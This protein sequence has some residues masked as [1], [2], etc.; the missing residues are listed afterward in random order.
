MALTQRLEFRQSQSLV[1]T[2]QLMQAIKLLQLSNLD[3]A[4]FVES[5][6][7][8]NPM[9][10][11]A[12]DGADPTAADV[13]DPAPA[14]STAAFADDG[15]GDRPLGQD[16]EPAPE[17]WM[18]RDL[19]SRAEI[20]Q[21]FDS[22]LENVFPEE[23]SEAAARTAQDSAPTAFTEWGGGASNDD[24]YNL[25]AFVAAEVTLAEHLAEQ[26]AV[27]MTAP[28]RRMIGQ[29]LIDLVDD[30]GYL[31]SDL[32][33]VGDKL[34]AETGEVTAVL[35]VLQTF[36]PPGICARNLS[37]C[38]AIQLREKDRYDPAM[39][40]LVEHLELLAKRDFA[41]LRRIC[42]VDDEDL[43]EMIGEIRHLDPKPG[44][45]FGATRTQTVVPDVYVRPGPDGGWL[46]ELNSDTLPRVLVNQSYYAE[47]SKTILKDGDRTYF[48]DC[49]Q[50][51]TWLV[52]ALDQRARTILKV[53]TEIVRQQDGFFTHGIAHLRP[54][55]LKVVADAIQMHES[56]VSRVTANK[57]MA[58]NRGIF[59]LKY[60]FTAS[61]A[62]ADGGSAHSAEAVR[63]H[64]R[65]LIDAEDPSAVLSDDTIV[66]RLREGGI[67]IA[68]R[69]VAK[70]REALRIPSSVQ[71]R[72]DK[73]NLP[74]NPRAASPTSPDHSS[75]ATPA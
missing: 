4:A 63:H 56:T 6:L 53:A 19:G 8:R 62:S 36:D 35:A 26:L 1:M 27:A 55:N 64:I 45:R 37:E 31:P 60:F 15:A 7:E 40:A 44:L 68:R 11:R 13:A 61:I 42:G 58:T 14:E 25:E 72:R 41:A 20:E 24:S 28:A 3:L 51:A 5:E 74:G 30:A 21:T 70:Y 34:G 17:E 10:E 33:D 12:G 65:R 50:N 48:T 32:G 9:L 73:Q 66:E 46:V 69:T 23:P 18:N 29:Y 54:L 59:E 75:D 47:L 71:R 22:G 43:A 57:Y 39:Q 16:S 38:L 49:L 52:R 2:P 67:D